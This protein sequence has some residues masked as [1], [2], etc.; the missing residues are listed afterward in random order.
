M[1]KDFNLSN[2]LYI[3]HENYCQSSLINR[4]FKHKNI[5]PLI[6]SLKHK[7]NFLVTEAGLS[8]E[9]REIFLI[10]TG[11]GPKKVFLW[12][13]MHGDEPTATMALFDIFNFFNTNDDL[14]ELKNKLLENITFYFMP[15]VNPD[16][17]E[18][19]QRRNAQ[20]ID[21]NRDAL[22]LQSPEAK[23]LM[24]TF[25]SI[26]ADFGFNLHDQST[27]YTV[28]KTFKST[29]ISFL[30]P[31][32]DYEKTVNSSRENAIKLI[33]NMINTLSDFIPGHMAKYTDDY[34]P[35]AFGD[36]FQKKGTSTILVESGGW[37]NDIEKQFIRILNFIAL[38]TAF[39]SIADETYKQISNHIYEN[40]PYNDESLFDLIIRNVH[41]KN[42]KTEIKADIGINFNEVSYDSAKNFYYQSELS[43]IGDL[44][45]FFAFS[46]YNFSGF[47][48]EAGKTYPKMFKSLKEIQK[49]N[50]HQLYSE[51]YTNIIL[52]VD[53]I[54]YPF[55]ILPFNICLK[56]KKSEKCRIL[57]ENP[58]N[59]IFKKG[60]KVKYILV[61]GFLYDVE[62]KT[63][64]IKNGLIVK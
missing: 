40:L 38:I 47:T 51:G 61:N 43:D 31:A 4:R 18:R 25:D 50:L 33:G 6:N 59:I 58:A 30:A 52:D 49:I 55:S 1:P 16:G 28:G 19:F 63:G 2:Y 60:G 12:S 23:I 54:N 64:N 11:K 56:T 57:L 36:N 3:N 9:G 5:L 22:K 44:S 14:S 29:A 37:Q 27:R 46:D 17:A 35:R 13:Q 39:E 20:D 15:M 24:S 45:T 41:I 62:N 48:V 7:K 32:L 8:L 21:V 34:E 26:K 53:E 42:N 10:K